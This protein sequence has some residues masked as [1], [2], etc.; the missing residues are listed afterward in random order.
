MLVH[1]QN[2]QLGHEVCLRGY[3]II[4]YHVMKKLTTPRGT[5]VLTHMIPDL[6]S[7]R[8]EGRARCLELSSIS[9]DAEITSHAYRAIQSALSLA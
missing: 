7:C 1:N 2:N 4:A 3:P 8:K 6:M 5:G 9:Y